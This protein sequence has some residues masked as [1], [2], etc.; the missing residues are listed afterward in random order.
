MKA[1]RFGI[2]TIFTIALI[3][4]PAWSQ[5]KEEKGG[6]G[7]VGGGYIPPRGPAPARAQAPRAQEPARPAGTARPET[8]RPRPPADIQGHPEAPHVHTNGQWIGHDSG[9]NDPHYHLDHPFEH[10]K[11]SGG[12]GK[13]HVWHLA[14]GGPNR[15]WFGNFYWSVAP[16]D[17]NL[18]SD[19]LWNGDQI[20]IYDDPD[21]A[22]WYLAYNVRLGTYCHVMYLGA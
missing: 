12:I 11:F 19:W 7:R 18:V 5:K 16:Y 22:G 8:P 17:L 14:G 13:G 2:V 6:G 3:A 20:V 4:V 1:L 10:G 9:K 21:H 15:F